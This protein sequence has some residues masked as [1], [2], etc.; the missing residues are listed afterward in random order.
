MTKWKQ[1]SNGITALI[2]PSGDSS[3]TFIE[4]CRLSSVASLS[5]RLVSFS[6]VWKKKNSIATLNWSS[7]LSSGASHAISL[8]GRRRSVPSQAATPV[9]TSH[10]ARASSAPTQVSEGG[11]HSF[12]VSVIH[13]H[14]ASGVLGYMAALMKAKL[15]VYMANL[16]PTPLTT[17]RNKQPFYALV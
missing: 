8:A 10:C 9:T 11:S 2:V 15:C 14:D 5:D 6:P 4:R 16:Q 12:R 17:P 7:Q 13:N 1:P 3:T